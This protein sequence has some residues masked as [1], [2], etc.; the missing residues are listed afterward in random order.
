MSTEEKDALVKSADM[1]ENMKA[2]A[3]EVAKEVS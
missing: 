2:Q 1:S 3:I